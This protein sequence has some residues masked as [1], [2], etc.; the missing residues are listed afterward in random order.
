[1]NGKTIAEKILGEKS[2]KEVNAGDF[3]IA[4]VDWCYVQ[5]GTGPLT[6]KQLE[7][8]NREDVIKNPNRTIV[9]IDHSAPSPRFELSND[10]IF[11]REFAMIND[12]VISDVGNGISHQIVC[13]KYIRPGDI[14]VGA[15][16][17]SCTG[18]ALCAFATG[19]GSTDVGVAMALGKTWLRVPETY[20]ISVDGEF[21]IGVYAKDLILHLIGLIGADGATYK[22]LEFT[23][24][25]IENMPMHDRMTL[26][27][28]AVEAG[29]K[30]G[31]MPSDNITKKYLSEHGREHEFREITP[32]LDAVYERE[33]NID[34]SELVPMVSMPHTVDNVKPI[35][36]IEG[37]K[38][39]QVLI[40][41]CT[42]GRIED[43]R[44]AAEFLK[45]RDIS[46]N[47]R[48]IVI[49]A[50]RDTFIKA[51]KEGLLN[52]FAESGAAVL[53]P[54]CGPCVG[55]HEGI[56]GDGEVCLSTQNR[57]FKG[58]MG[59]PNSEIYLASP[60]TCAVS[61]I[62]GNIADPRW[63]L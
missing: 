7:K 49:P 22:S 19:M 27:N 38:I 51:S 8:I 9:F 6:I 31:L 48:L 12:I 11:L 55:I 45:D 44:I 4:C 54:G 63:Y 18:G 36:E 50:S 23:G 59:N 24:K 28:M 32:D 20:K 2:G 53:A 25:T 17:H 26:S 15:D 57:N 1:M 60:A 16:S 47:V 52:I 13:E 56:L 41:T 10:H 35:D 34:V 3:V 5:D 21:P 40:G 46:E 42:N 58:R 30:C 43:L 39:H 37:T 33:I 62:E 61:A 29:A 14:V